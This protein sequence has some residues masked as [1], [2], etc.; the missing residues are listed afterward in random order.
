MNFVFALVFCVI[1]LASGE[2]DKLSTMFW[3]SLHIFV[4]IVEPTLHIFSPNT[5]KRW[6]S[7]YKIQRKKQNWIN[8]YN[9]NNKSNDMVLLC[10]EYLCRDCWTH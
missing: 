3:I 10:F 5:C 1:L 7:G 2:N 4:G 6:I 9:D 8:G